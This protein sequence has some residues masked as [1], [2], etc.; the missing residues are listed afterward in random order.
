MAHV[1]QS[2]PDFGIAFLTKVLQ[3]DKIVLS[4]FGSGPTPSPFGGVRG[5]HL[6][7]ILGVCVT[8]SAPHEA[9]KLI[10]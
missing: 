3:T 10:A 5:F 7:Q 1:G 4:L 2:R 6:P 8:T 9:L